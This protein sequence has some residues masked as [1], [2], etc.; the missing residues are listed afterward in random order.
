M[1]DDKVIPFRPSRPETDNLRQVPIGGNRELD[2]QPINVWECECGGVEFLLHADGRVQC[3]VCGYFAA[4][5][6]CNIPDPEAS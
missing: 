2:G 6:T 1:S 4:P 5:V 3:V